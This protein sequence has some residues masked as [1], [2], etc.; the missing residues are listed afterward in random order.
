MVQ[1]LGMKKLSGEQFPPVSKLK[2]ERLPG[3]KLRSLNQDSA[4]GPGPPAE[5]LPT[6]SKGRT[7]CAREEWLKRHVQQESLGDD[8]ATFRPGMT[9]E[10]IGNVIMRETEE[11]QSKRIKLLPASS[12]VEVLSISS[13]SER[14]MHVRDADGVD[15]WVSIR[16]ESDEEL[17]ALIPPI[18]AGCKLYSREEE[19]RCFYDV[20][21]WDVICLVRRGEHMFATGQ[22]VS[23][24]GY[25]MVPVRLRNGAMGAVQLELVSQ[26]PEVRG[27]PHGTGHRHEP[28]VEVTPWD[29]ELVHRL[30]PKSQCLL[31]IVIYGDGLTG[32]DDPVYAHRFAAE[33][34][35][36]GLSTEV[37]TCG[38]VGIT[39]HHLAAGRDDKALRDIQKRAGPGLGSL[40]R[41]EKGSPSVGL[42]IITAGINDILRFNREYN[43]REPHQIVEALL[44]LHQLCNSLGVPTVAVGMPDVGA[45]SS[46]FI[47]GARKQVNSLLAKW[48]EESPPGSPRLFVNPA[49]LLP[50]GPRAKRHGLWR[51]ELHVS[52]KGSELLGLRLAQQVMPLVKELH[53][54]SI[55]D[56]ADPSTLPLSVYMEAVEVHERS[57]LMENAASNFMP[58]LRK[59]QEP[60]ATLLQRSWRR[61]RMRAPP[62]AVDSKTGLETLHL[63]LGRCLHWCC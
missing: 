8:G 12:K 51:D 31:R 9:L 10:S 26:R 60:A 61:S 40:L 14:R 47:G 42:V 38:L 57:H 41:P 27:V 6:S 15:G 1:L 23:N 54:H 5:T 46:K 50:H 48:V 59:W 49:A 3:C 19:L 20:E 25:T 43:K 52:T 37:V 24:E 13:K 7:R 36:E 28:E 56:A 45:T 18:T 17:W 29:L 53:S 11:L 35:C 63:Y 58:V 22:P 32:E 16:K 4:A 2:V 62:D 34:D 33:L 21:S 30:P 55:L 39:A 44:T